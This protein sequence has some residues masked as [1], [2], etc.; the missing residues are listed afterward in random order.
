M[1]TN[2]THI[3]ISCESG[4]AAASL[5]NVDLANTIL[6]TWLFSSDCRLLFSPKVKKGVQIFKRAWVSSR[7]R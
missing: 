7:C 4:P 6:L 3:I 2:V 5:L 1:E